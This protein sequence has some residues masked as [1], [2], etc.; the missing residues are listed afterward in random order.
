M[1][2]LSIKVTHCLKC[3]L[4]KSGRCKHPHALEKVVPTEGNYL[5]RPDWCPL[6]HQSV[7][8]K[9]AKT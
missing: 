8:I 7:T 2:S 4:L 5:D 9:L 6:A 1:P 3:P